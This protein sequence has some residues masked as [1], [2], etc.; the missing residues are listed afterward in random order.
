MQIDSRNS[1]STVIARILATTAMYALSASGSETSAARS[2]CRQFGVCS[3]G[4]TAS[5]RKGE[6][7]QAEIDSRKAKKERV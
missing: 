5:S 7:M 6:L 4:A 3:S 2:G 1:S